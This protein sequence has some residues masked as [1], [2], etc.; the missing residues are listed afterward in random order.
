MFPADSV[1]IRSEHPGKLSAKMGKERSQW[2][3]LLEK[4]L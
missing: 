3:Y 1:R 4:L 2:G